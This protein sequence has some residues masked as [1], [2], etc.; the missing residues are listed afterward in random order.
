M[1]NKLNHGD[2]FYLQL[3]NKE[4]YITSGVLFDV[5]HLQSMSK[6]EYLKNT[7]LGYN[8]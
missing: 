5:A 8:Y 3:K 6:I 2:V 4:K 7:I 1:K